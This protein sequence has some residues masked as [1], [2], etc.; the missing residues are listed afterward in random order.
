MANGLT[1]RFIS[2]PLTLEQLAL[3]LRSLS[4]SEHETL[5]ILMH[6]RTLSQLKQSIQDASDGKIFPLESI[7][8]D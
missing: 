2:L 1:N 8:E 6:K 7:L 5:G 4:K 3:G